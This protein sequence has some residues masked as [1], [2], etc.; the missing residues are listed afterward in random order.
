[1]QRFPR[2]VAPSQP[3]ASARLRAGSVANLAARTKLGWAPQRSVEGAITDVIK[4]VKQN[5]ARLRE[6][7]AEYIHKE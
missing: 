5:L 1:M 7:P 4:W 3:E 6:L 2:F